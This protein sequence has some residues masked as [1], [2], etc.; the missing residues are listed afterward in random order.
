MTGKPWCCEKEYREAELGNLMP[1]AGT[2]TGV[3]FTVVC[4]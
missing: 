4:S 1:V 2:G 3:S